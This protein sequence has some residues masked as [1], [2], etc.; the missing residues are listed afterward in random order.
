MPPDTLP[1]VHP[2]WVHTALNAWNAPD[3]GWVITIFLS[4]RILPPPTGTSEVLASAAGAAAAPEP[5]PAG[6]AGE[7]AGCAGWL[8]AT[9]PLLEL[10]VLHPASTA[11]HAAPA[12]ASTVRRLD[13]A[14]LGVGLLGSAIVR[15]PQR[16]MPKVEKNQ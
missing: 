14:T 1:T 12:Q 16:L 5:E 8:P 6:A 9:P 3:C 10:Y 2:A 11:A 7:V 4:A 15:T 13:T